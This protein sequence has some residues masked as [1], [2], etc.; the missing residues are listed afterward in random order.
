MSAKLDIN[1][2]IHI[3]LDLDLENKKAF[4][5]ALKTEKILYSPINLSFQ[6]LQI[7][8]GPKGPP[9]FRLLQILEGR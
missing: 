2:F 5:W 6:G 7:L 3:D 9:D 4:I 1:G 8:L